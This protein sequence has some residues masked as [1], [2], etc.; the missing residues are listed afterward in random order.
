MEHLQAAIKAQ[1]IADPVLKITAIVRQLGYAV[2]LL[3]DHLV[4]VSGKRPE[5]GDSG[6]LVIESRKRMFCSHISNLAHWVDQNHHF[7]LD[8]F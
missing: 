6:G 7:S 2:Y 5:S 1:G 3:N 4:W 8:L